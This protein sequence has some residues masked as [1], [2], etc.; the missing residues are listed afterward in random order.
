MG[1]VEKAIK[2]LSIILISIR[3]VKDAIKVINALRDMYKA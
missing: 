1:T 3:V 2:I